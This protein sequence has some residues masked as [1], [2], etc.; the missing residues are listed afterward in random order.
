MLDKIQQW[1]LKCSKYDGHC[2]WDFFLHN[3]YHHLSFISEHLTHVVSDGK[4][5]SAWKE[6]LWALSGKSQGLLITLWGHELVFV[7][8][9]FSCNLKYN[10]YKRGF[11]TSASVSRNSMHKTIFIAKI[12]IC[13]QAKMTKLNLDL[14]VWDN[15]PPLP[16]CCSRKLMEYWHN[17]NA[18]IRIV[19]DHS[20]AWGI[21][22]DVVRLM[23]GHSRVG[24]P[25]LKPQFNSCLWLELT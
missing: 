12:S 25:W 7:R 17:Q 6:G 14:G 20:L 19:Y 23:S 4:V 13:T 8:N 9:C 15:H 5:Y 2:H 22:K 24:L 21:P 18:L 1:N 16:C 11:T 10:A 3:N